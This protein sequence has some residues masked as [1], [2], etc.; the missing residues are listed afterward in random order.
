MIWKKRSLKKE[1]RRMRRRI[2]SIGAASPRRRLFRREMSVTG[3]VGSALVESPSIGMTSRRITLL[4]VTRS[5]KCIWMIMMTMIPRI[6][7]VVIVCPNYYTS[8]NITNNCYDLM[9]RMNTH[10][11]NDRNHRFITPSP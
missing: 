11:R 10:N 7:T 4:M 8:S 2:I 1:R 3:S 5:R 9:T 6:C